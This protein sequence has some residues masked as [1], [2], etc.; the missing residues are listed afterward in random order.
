MTSH[1]QLHLGFEHRP[2]LGGEDFLV[3]DCNQEAMAWLDSWPAWPG[4]ALAVYGPA[5][6]GKSHLAQVFAIRTGGPILTISD[7]GKKTPQMFFEK[8]K[9]CVVEDADGVVAAG[10]EEALLHLHNTA[11]ETG[12]H[13]LYTSRHPPARWGGALPDL[14]SRVAAAPAVAVG[15][16][17]DA[18]MAAVLVKLFADRQLKVDKEVLPYMIARMERSFAAA[19]HLVSALDEIALAEHRNIT[20]PLVRRVI[21]E[22]GK[23]WEKN[24]V[25]GWRYGPDLRTPLSQSEK[26]V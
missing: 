10:L 12:R 17:D 8:A 9:A 7:L 24:G 3:A 2:A 21:K 15:S 22:D 5:G 1:P 25:S 26:L 18:L 14:A 4:A 19:G 13:I 23:R 11:Q 6:C 16:P 20:L